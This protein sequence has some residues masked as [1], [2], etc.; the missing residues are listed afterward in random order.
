M[1]RK[2]QKDKMH[3]IWAEQQRAADR[4]KMTPEERQQMDE[5]IAQAKQMKQKANTREAT[6][7][8]AARRARRQRK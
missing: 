8:R 6:E 3:D 5:A 4:A 2:T 7:K 1:E